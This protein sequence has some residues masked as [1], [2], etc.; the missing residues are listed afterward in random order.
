MADSIQSVKPTRKS[1]AKA[2]RCRTEFYTRKRKHLAGSA[3]LSA[4]KIALAISIIRARA[5][6]AGEPPVLPAKGSQFIVA[7]YNSC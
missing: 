2:S 6:N 4:C 3:R 7:N 1:V 5:L